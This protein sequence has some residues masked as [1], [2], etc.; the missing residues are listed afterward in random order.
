MTHPGATGNTDAPGPSPAGPAARVADAAST[1]QAG[2]HEFARFYGDYIHRLAAYIMYQGAS[3]HLA[4]DI[5]Q[6]AM[7]TAYRRWPEIKSPRAYAWTIAYR[8]FTRH[9]LSDP[10]QTAGEVPEPAPLLP[11]PGE[12]E[13]WLQEQHVIHVLRALPPRQRQVLALT[14]DGWTPAEIAEMLGLEPAAVRS[15]L[16]KARRSADG[17]HRRTGEEAP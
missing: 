4:A 6:D 1:T 12:A 10:E 7:I 8:A 2:E 13:T 11:R 16:R 14:I 5:A 17:H 3:A 15:S 9:A